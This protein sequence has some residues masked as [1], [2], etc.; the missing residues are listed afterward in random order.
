MNRAGE[1]RTKKKHQQKHNTSMMMLTP[2]H[3]LVVRHQS[4]EEIKDIA[5]TFTSVQND[6]KKNSKGTGNRVTAT[7]IEAINKLQLNT[8]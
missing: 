1:E 8:I 7:G 2:N 3:N 6:E 5:G 4:E